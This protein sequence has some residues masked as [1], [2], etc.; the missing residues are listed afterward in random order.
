MSS[1]PPIS[2]RVATQAVIQGVHSSAAT[3]SATSVPPGILALPSGTFLKGT[4]T[5]LRPQNIALLHTSKGDILIQSDVLLQ[6]GN[7]VVLRLETNNQG[8]QAR[9]ISVDGQTPR[10]NPNKV[11]VGKLVAGGGTA[12]ASAVAP[13]AVEN[14]VEVKL[15][16]AMPIRA[17]LLTISEN[18]DRLV[19]QLSPFV[20]PQRSAASGGG[21]FIVKV[22]PQTLRSPTILPPNQQAINALE[23]ATIATDSRRFPRNIPYAAMQNAQTSKLGEVRYASPV[24]N[25]A[26]TSGATPTRPTGEM[27]QQGQLLA[28]VIGTEKSG[29][30]MVKTAL[31]NLL[32][33]LPQLSGNRQIQ[34]PQ[35]SELLIQLLPLNPQR[36]AEG[37]SQPLQTSPEANILQLSNHWNSLRELLQLLQATHPALAT[38]LLQTIIPSAS[39]GSLASSLLFFISAIRGGNVRQWLGNDV[40]ATVENSGHGGLL[41]KLTREFSNLSKLMVDPPSQNWQAVIFPLHYKDQLQQVKFFL[42]R[43]HGNAQDIA[44]DAAT[45]RF[46]VEV[47]L[48]NLGSLQCDGLLKKTKEQQIFDLIIR[49]KAPLA[50][51]HRDVIRKIYADGSKLTGYSGT[52]SFQ[53]EYPFHVMPM[54]EIASNHSNVVA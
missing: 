48:S 47:E 24:Q 54:Q 13:T 43:E 15:S 12:A 7:E 19:K 45:R 41:K 8:L 10:D 9:I 14:P 17:T 5:A 23:A 52:I 18:F 39:G 34:L 20:I 42:R 49:S 29:Q 38:Q 28:Q 46:I 51:Q 3:D 1:S 44:N 40:V 6:R 2:G 35:G 31:G 37:Q 22:L 30:T 21:Q 25:L 50:A 33:D 16:S 27:L 32:I 36:A 4:V 53:T 11:N 26:S